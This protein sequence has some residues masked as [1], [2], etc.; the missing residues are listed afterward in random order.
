MHT[1]YSSDSPLVRHL[2]TTWWPTWQPIRF[3]HVLS[4]AYKQFYYIIFLVRIRKPCIT[5]LN[6]NGVY[7]EH[8]TG[9]EHFVVIINSTFMS[10]DDRLSCHKMY[11]HY[12]IDISLRRHKN[13][14]MSGLP[15]AI[16][17]VESEKRPA[18]VLVTLDGMKF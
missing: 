7:F 11:R 13:I 4:L 2:L 10:L 16:F 9:C 3:I 12:R 14:D 6:I 17:T 8:Q 5:I 18:L 15:A 1:T